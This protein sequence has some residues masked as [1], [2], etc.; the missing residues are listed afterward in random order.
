MAVRVG[1]DVSLHCPLLA[2]GRGT[3]SWYRQLPGRSPELVL[4]TRSSSAVAFG[5]RFGPERVRATAGGSLVLRAAQRS[6][7]G[8]YFCSIGRGRE[9]GSGGHAAGN[10]A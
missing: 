10:R 5:S 8:L 2:A 3:L 6:D 7:S 9:R 4:S 1:E